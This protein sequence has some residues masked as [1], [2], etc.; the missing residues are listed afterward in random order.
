MALNIQIYY[1]NL[2]PPNVITLKYNIKATA[3]ARTTKQQ[4]VT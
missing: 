1:L 2:V 4:P 3:A